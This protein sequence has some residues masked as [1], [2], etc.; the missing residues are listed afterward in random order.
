MDDNTK[1]ELWKL[2]KLLEQNKAYLDSL[3][4]LLNAMS[5]FIEEFITRMEDEQTESNDNGHL[6]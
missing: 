4:L 2:V 3:K 5:E 1:D 6:N